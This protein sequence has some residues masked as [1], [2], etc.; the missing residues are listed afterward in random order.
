M[1]HRFDRLASLIHFFSFLSNFFLLIFFY[2]FDWKLN[3]IIYFVYFSLNYHD[4]IKKI[5]YTPYCKVLFIII[6][7][8]FVG[9]Y[10]LSKKKK[11]YSLINSSYCKLFFFHLIKTL[12]IC[13]SKLRDLN[14][15]LFL[16]NRFFNSYCVII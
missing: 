1:D 4:F 11:T 5:Y 7:L 12:S 16:F 8:C 13:L 10:V 2:Q 6:I 3:F 14:L 9:I 15:Y